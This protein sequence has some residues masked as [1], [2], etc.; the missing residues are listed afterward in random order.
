MSEM[1]ASITGYEGLYEV[2]N[3][4]RVKSLPRRVHYSAGF[5]RLNEGRILAVAP[6]SSNEKCNYYRVTLSKANRTKYFPIH[7]LVAEHFVDR[8]DGCDVV[9]H[10]DGNKQNNHA[11]NLE[12][13]TQSGNKLHAVY[14]GLD[15]P[16]FGIRPVYCVTNCTKYPSA[17]YAARELELDESA[18]SKVCRGVYKKTKGMVFRY[19]G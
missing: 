14:S 16:P 4:G 11:S 18:I 6:A 17:S 7:R 9:N 15:Y 2:S 13:V 12:W 10:K 8:V 5:D 3:Y 19:A 1:W